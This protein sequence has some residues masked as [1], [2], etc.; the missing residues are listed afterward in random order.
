MGQY[1]LSFYW[2]LQLGLN[3]RYERDQITISFP[4]VEMCIGLT[5]DAH[6][7]RFFKD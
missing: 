7:I 4:F 6:G 2:Y 3:F 1:R 5:P